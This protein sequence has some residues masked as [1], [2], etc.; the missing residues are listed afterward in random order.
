MLPEIPQAFE[1]PFDEFVKQASLNE[2]AAVPSAFRQTAVSDQWF[3]DKL[4]ATLS[5]MF[6][7]GANAGADVE[8]RRR[9]LSFSAEL[10]L[11]L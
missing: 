8:R 11:K 3:R 1:D 7:R 4:H 10:S 5:E 6:E 2:I 9:P